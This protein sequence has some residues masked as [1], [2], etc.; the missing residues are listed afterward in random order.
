MKLIAQSPHIPARY[1]MNYGVWTVR[2]PR[3]GNVE[4]SNRR[5]RCAKRCSECPWSIGA[6]HEQRMPGAM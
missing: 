3:P 1:R 4:R 2:R 6:S 5:Q